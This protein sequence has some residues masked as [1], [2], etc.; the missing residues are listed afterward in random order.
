M[1]VLHFKIQDRPARSPSPMGVLNAFAASTYVCRPPDGMGCYIAGNVPARTILVAS[2]ATTLPA[3]SNT[4][5]SASL[6]A[7]LA[8]WVT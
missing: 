6:A 5:S 2:W 4:T 8:A 7:S 3:S 1:R